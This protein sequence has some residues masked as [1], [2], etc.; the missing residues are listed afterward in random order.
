MN[1]ITRCANGVIADT[2]VFNRLQTA[3]SATL[4]LLSDTHGAVSAVRWIFN[5]F[6]HL[7]DACLFAG[8][9]AD[10][11]LSLVREAAAGVLTIPP[12]V[13]MAQGNC[14]SESYP[15]V[16]H[17][18]EAAKPFGLPLYQQKLIAGQRILLVHGHFYHVELD[19]RKLCMAAENQGCTIAVHGHT[20]IQSIERF[21]AV[22]AINPGSPLR[23]RGTSYGGFAILS[24][25]MPQV[26]PS[27][28]VPV[29][30]AA[31]IVESIMEAPPPPA[32][33]GLVQFYRLIQDGNGLFSADQ[34][35]AYP[36]PFITVS[37]V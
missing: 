35:A 29:S 32:S 4:L 27:A 9:G 10:D 14:D 12:V 3:D 25:Q 17:D 5:A 7:C 1:N 22:T 21:G 2:A 34:Y 13:L 18:T 11:I 24:L 6:S 16:L 28:A 20:H 36:I 23:P 26:Q 37:K 31:S 30:A 33:F 8:D 19:D 15:P